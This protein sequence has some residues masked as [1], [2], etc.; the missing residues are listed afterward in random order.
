MVALGWHSPAP[1]VMSE[2]WGRVPSVR[3]TVVQMLFRAFLVFEPRTSYVLDK[4][5]VI[6]LYPQLGAL[7][8]LKVSVMLEVIFL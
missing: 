4:H 5:S 7:F 6:E 8:L 1:P 2:C 3:N